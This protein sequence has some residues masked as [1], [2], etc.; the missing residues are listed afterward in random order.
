MVLS[1]V[2]SMVLGNVVVYGGGGREEWMKN[3]MSKSFLFLYINKE[4]KQ[5]KWRS[6]MA[7]E[8]RMKNTDI[9]QLEWV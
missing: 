4:S 5:T 9:D 6:V 8:A 7:E 3:I 2:L 1:I